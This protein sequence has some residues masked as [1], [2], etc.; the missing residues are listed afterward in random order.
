MLKNRTSRENY[1]MECTEPYDG[2]TFDI[3]DTHLDM[4]QDGK[5][6]RHIELTTNI[7]L[8]LNRIQGN[9]FIRDIG[10]A[11]TWC[12]WLVASDNGDEINERPLD[13]WSMCSNWEYNKLENEMIQKMIACNE[14]V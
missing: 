4:Y 9:P 5:R 1:F 10:W 14:E 6:I 13:Y 3:T 12:V 8:E 2:K 7:K 11:R